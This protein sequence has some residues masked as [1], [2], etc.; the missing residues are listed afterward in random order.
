MYLNIKSY[1][2]NFD[3]FLVQFEDMEVKYDVMIFSECLVS[4]HFHDPYT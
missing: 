4:D 1:N 2:K 3:Q